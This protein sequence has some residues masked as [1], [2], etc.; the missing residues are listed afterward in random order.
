MPYALKEA[1]FWSGILLLMVVAMTSDYTVRLLVRLGVKV[2]KSYYEQ[3]V[4]SQFGQKGYVAVSAAMGIFAYGAMVAYLI[5]IGEWGGGGEKR[6]GGEARREEGREGLAMQCN[7]CHVPLSTINSSPVTHSP[8]LPSFLPS[9]LPLPASLLPLVVAGD[10][11][12]I[13]VAHWG[14]IDLHADPWVKRV[15]LVSLAT[16]AVLPLALLKNMAALSKTSFISLMSVVFI[17]GVVFAQA[18]GGTGDARVPVTEA[19]RTLHFIDT[20]FF[21]AI[22]IIAFAFVCHH[23]CF[24]VYNTLRDNTEARWAKTV[25]LSIGVAW[26]VMILLAMSA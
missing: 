14:G 21:P 24:I 4:Q 25:H 26:T 7:A 10:T 18:I 16:G 1:G 12:S 20:S 2:K 5:G 17:L 9:L 23:A 22:G 8:L 15:V 6:G 11:M 3:L 19:E 13:V